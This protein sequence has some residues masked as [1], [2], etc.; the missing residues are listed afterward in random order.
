VSQKGVIKINARRVAPR[1]NAI[2]AT[3][4]TATTGCIGCERG[5]HLNVLPTKRDPFEFPGLFEEPRP[6][7]TVA[8]PGLYTCQLDHAFYKIIYARAKELASDQCLKGD[9]IPESSNID[10]AVSQRRKRSKQA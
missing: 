8:L 6:N 10:T 9:D 2:D 7:S 3:A 4:P 5:D 1:V